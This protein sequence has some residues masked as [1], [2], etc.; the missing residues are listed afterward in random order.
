[1][2]CK[3]KLL[4]AGK[5]MLGRGLTVETFGNLSI[6]DPETGLVYLT[7]SAMAY[8]TITED[9][10][11]VMDPLFGERSLS[12]YEQVHD[13][14]VFRSY[15]AVRWEHNRASTLNGEDLAFDTVS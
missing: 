9:D 5:E 14:R 4:W 1:M 15:E 12:S 6:R 2:N 3:E 13:I 8:H 11:V 7:P 10:V